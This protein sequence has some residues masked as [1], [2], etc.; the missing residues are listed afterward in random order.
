MPELGSYG[1]VRGA[2]GNSRPYRDHAPGTAESTRMTHMRHWAGQG[3]ATEREKRS[4]PRASSS[5][6]VGSE[7]YHFD[8]PSLSPYLRLSRGLGPPG[9]MIRIWPGDYSGRHMIGQHGANT[10]P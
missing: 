10:P 1:S 7:L 8:P 6:R 9:Q 5:G 4:S 2:A 3:R